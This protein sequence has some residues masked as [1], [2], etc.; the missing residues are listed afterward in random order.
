MKDVFFAFAMR[1]AAAVEI[2]SDATIEDILSK[3]D[4]VNIARNCRHF[5]S[6]FEWRR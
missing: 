2:N 4:D 3:R 6:G 1:K 5:L